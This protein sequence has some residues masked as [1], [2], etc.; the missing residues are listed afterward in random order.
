M[1]CSSDYKIPVYPSNKLAVSLH[2]YNPSPFTR[3]YYF[4]PYNW[5]DENG[6]V[7]NNEPVLSWGNQDEYFQIITDFELMKN[8]FVN[9]GIPVIISEVTV[10]TEEKKS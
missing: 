8:C 7:Y 2:Y 1:T 6:N 10:L 9:K 5:T 3:E 4:D